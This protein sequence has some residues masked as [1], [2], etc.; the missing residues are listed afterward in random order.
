MRYQ[1]V[2]FKAL[3]QVSVI[4][5]FALLVA[6]VFGATVLAAD[7]DSCEALAAMKVENTNILSA[8]V[9]P[10]AGDMPEYCRVLGYVR[11]AIN[12]E[13]RLPTDWNGKF[14]MAGCGGY[15]GK[16]DSD[17]AGFINAMSYGL[18]RGYAASTMDSGHWG[19][20]VMDGRWADH[21]PVAEADWGHRAVHE[22]Q[23]VTKAVIKAYYG[24][25]PVKSYF[26]GCSTGGRMALM[27][28]WK[29]PED[30]DGI[31]CGAPAMDYTGLVATFFAWLVQSNTGPDGKDIITPAKVGLIQKAV[32]ERCD[33]LDG[34]PDGLIDDP[35]QCDFDP[36][37]LQ[38]PVGQSSKDCL[39][40]AEVKTLKAWYGSPK[41][42]AGNQLYPGGVPLC[43]E[44]YWWLWLTG[45]VKGAGRLIP[46]FAA[47]FLAYMAFRD[48]PGPAYT[49]MDFDFDKDPE[50][51][52]YMAAVYNSD[53]PDL[54]KF[55][56]RGGRLI[57]WHGWADTIV[58]PFKTV[59]Y[60]NAVEQKMRGK[61]ENLD[62]LRLFM[63]PGMD[64]CGLL[65]GPGIN[66][67]GFD[68]LSALEAWVERGIP[69][70][71]LL[72]TKK[73]KK[74]ETIRTRPLC[75]YP[76]TTKYKG[77]G[78]IND[79]ADFECVNP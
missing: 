4:A 18:A 15:C 56:E 54:L 13:I 48:D 66:Q 55:K 21:N 32:Y 11:P 58:P 33:K 3:M 5:C 8:T 71:S 40:E 20:S 26:Q 41:D 16:L 68:P 60:Y 62:F 46:L 10:A 42:S 67:M 79:S 38:C 30:F 57:M 51:L 2:H 44:P 28:A 12:F 22:T 63:V 17:R 49:A 29:Y 43:S 52:E 25:D 59:D 45:N 24:K 9:V 1:I 50:K 34:L 65:S 76:Q 23:R 69:P 64:H 77:S 74:G 47:D 73:N 36:A 70:E 19:S 39:T 78:D 53:N 75:P 72:A 27:E 35:R 61:A 14:Y 6:F 31:I 37:S 7:L